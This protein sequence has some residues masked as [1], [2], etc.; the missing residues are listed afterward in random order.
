M[1]WMCD[2]RLKIVEVILNDRRIWQ[3]D[4]LIGIIDDIIIRSIKRIGRHNVII[5]WYS[6]KL[7]RITKFNIP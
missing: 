4:S 1:L 2:K 3:S 6:R 7:E 5:K